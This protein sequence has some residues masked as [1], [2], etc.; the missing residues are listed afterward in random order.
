MTV[1][2]STGNMSWVNDSIKQAV[3]DLSTYIY[4]QTS[5]SVSQ[6]ST[7]Q[8][9]QS[10]V[11]LKTSTTTESMKSISSNLPYIIGGV[12]ISGIVLAVVIAAAAIGY[13]YAKTGKLPG[14]KV[15]RVERQWSINS[16]RKHPINRVAR[17]SQAHHTSHRLPL[18]L[19]L[20]P[21]PSCCPLYDLLL[22]EQTTQI[23]LKFTRNIGNGIA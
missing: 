17:Y 13:G 16:S 1:G 14:M 3:Q 23:H 8:N 11:E 18:S 22:N 4:I 19:L 6:G 9:Q 15:K 12:G 7:R 20:L 21:R 10:T 2:T 5:R